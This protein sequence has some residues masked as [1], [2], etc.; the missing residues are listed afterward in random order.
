MKCALCDKQHDKPGA[1][2]IVYKKK[3]KT[4][5]YPICKDCYFSEFAGM[6]EMLG[7]LQQEE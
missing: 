2:L 1:T 3:G 4:K 6:F 7:G 5:K